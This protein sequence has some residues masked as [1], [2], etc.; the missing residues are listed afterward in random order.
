MGTN[1]SSKHPLELPGNGGES[2]GLLSGNVRAECD[3]PRDP[4]M[5][6]YLPK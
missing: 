2:M 1:H 6:E 5:I 3:A 4:V